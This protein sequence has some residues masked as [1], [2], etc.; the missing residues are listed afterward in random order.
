MEPVTAT[1]ADIGAYWRYERADRKGALNYED[2]T[3][4]ADVLRQVD[5]GGK[6][7]LS[8]FRRVFEAAATD[9]ER[10]GFLV[11]N[12]GSLDWR[13]DPEFVAWLANLERTSRDDADTLREIRKYSDNGELPSRPK[14]ATKR[15]GA[16]WAKDWIE[17]LRS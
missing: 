14:P 2:E 1:E 9:E 5:R 15:K 3:T 6:A 12:L 13:D 11:G 7:G 8:L 4:W 16:R 17:D 10:A